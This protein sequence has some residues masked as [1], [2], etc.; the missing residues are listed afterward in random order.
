[1]KGKLQ[2]RKPENWQDFETLCKKLWGEIWGCPSTI[3]KHGR[4]G[5]NQHG[6]DIYA[7]PINEQQ[8]FG[9][10]C[11]GK[12]DYSKS[13]LTSAEIDE[14]IE[15]ARTFSPPL[16]SFFFAT[17]ANKDAKIEEYVRRKN[18][19]SITNGGFSIDIF[20]WEDIVDLI[21][22]NKDTYNW[23]LHD[24]PFSDSYK[25]EVDI[26]GKNKDYPYTLFPQ[27]HKNIKRYQLKPPPDP[28]NI[29]AG[30]DLALK[31]YQ[32]F[33]I[34]IPWMK[35]TYNYQWCTIYLHIKN[36]G[37]LPLENY[38]IEVSFQEGSIQEIDEPSSYTSN[39][40]LPDAM[41]AE[42]NRQARE[43][44][45]VFLYNDDDDSLL[46]EAKK[47][48]IQKDSKSFSFAVKPILGVKQLNVHWELKARNFDTEGDCCLSVEPIIEENIST[49]LVDNETEIKPDEVTIEPKKI[50][51]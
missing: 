37:S 29:F 11:K 3:K 39:P 10:Q 23:Y 44:Q 41:K 40:L 26:R 7:I 8:Y 1:M 51:K 43:S 24:L 28:R 31:D 50:T 19:E 20:S 6:V 9:I 16:K 47:D 14:E 2:L 17:T 21:E 33:N 34:G 5:Q 49:V 25:I 13:Q 42:L 45:E 12:D 22:S 38:N 48:L 36:T 30:L 27:F 18:I 35:T 4:T 46:I 15:K 32:P